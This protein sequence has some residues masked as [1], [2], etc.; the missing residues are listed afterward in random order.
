MSYNWT[1]SNK[2][3]VRHKVAYLCTISWWQWFCTEVDTWMWL[4]VMFLLISLV[5]KGFSPLA[6]SSFTKQPECAI[7]SKLPNQKC[8]D[9]RICVIAP[10]LSN[11]SLWK[12]AYCIGKKN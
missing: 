2:I 10:A 3:L 9:M 11:R 1:K 5:Q 4:L 8:R 12:M 6:F 7:D